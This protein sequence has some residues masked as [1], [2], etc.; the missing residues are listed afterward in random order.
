MRRIRRSRAGSTGNWRDK[1]SPQSRIRAGYIVRQGPDT[2]EFEQHVTHGRAERA[3]LFLVAD[4]VGQPGDIVA[5]MPALDWL[6]TWRGLAWALNQETTFN[7]R[8]SEHNA[9]KVHR[10]PLSWLRDGCRGIVLTRARLAANFLCDAG[11]LLADNVKH[12]K[13]LKVALTRPA[14]QIMVPQS[15]GAMR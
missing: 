15:M 7:P 4:V 2:F 12:G 11:P 6:G 10:D 9:L 8:L 5:W 14:P 3:F 13:D 1:A